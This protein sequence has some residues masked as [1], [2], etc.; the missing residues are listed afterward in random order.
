M[1]TIGFPKKKALLKN[2][3]SGGGGVESSP[4]K[5]GGW[6]GAS[7]N[8]APIFPQGKTGSFPQRLEVTV[9]SPAASPSASP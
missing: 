7:H 8:L 5:R 1:K 6:V 3:I 9:A 2:H 4:I